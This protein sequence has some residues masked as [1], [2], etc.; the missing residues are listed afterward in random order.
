MQG[1]RPSRP[2]DI[3]SIAGRVV[4]RSFLA[5]ESTTGSGVPIND[6][7]LHLSPTVEI[8]SAVVG[9]VF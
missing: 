6:T 2:F 1:R 7:A 3:P 8:R 5:V 4:M 9:R